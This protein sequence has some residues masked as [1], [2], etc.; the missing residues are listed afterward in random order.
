MN[1]ILRKNKRGAALVEYVTLLGLIGVIAVGAVMGVGRE[2]A[3]TFDVVTDKLS[4]NMETAAN[5]GTEDA[6][7]EAEDAPANA[8]G[9]IVDGNAVSILWH[10]SQPV[11]D[12]ITFSG[13]YIYVDISGVTDHF[14]D[15][16]GQLAYDAHVSQRG[17]FWNARPES[18]KNSL[19]NQQ[20][21]ISS[22]IDSDYATGAAFVGDSDRRKYPET[23]THA[24]GE[25]VARNASPGLR[26]VRIRRQF[27]CGMGG[28]RCV[29]DD[30]EFGF[31]M[32]PKP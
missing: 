28:S 21:T 27:F 4:Q 14:T 2:T 11:P 22:T 9:V 19:V 10:S 15:H 12:Y 5:G 25:H 3:D 6:L 31:K 18:W 20:I 32:Y 30:F 29:A 16:V 13:Q 23:T 24:Y 26:N 7:P 1:R 17:H 8:G